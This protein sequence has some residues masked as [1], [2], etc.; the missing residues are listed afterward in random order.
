MWGQFIGDV[1]FL[2]RR[3][4]FLAE[5]FLDRL[6][7]KFMTNRICS[8]Q[9][10]LSFYDKWTFVGSLEMQ[11][12]VIF[13]F[14]KVFFHLYFEFI[15]SY[16]LAQFSRHTDNLCIEYLLSFS[17]IIS[18]FNCLPMYYVIFWILYPMPVIW[19][20]E[21]FTAFSFLRLVYKL[22][23]ITIVFYSSVFILF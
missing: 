21:K 13:H 23:F 16:L 17:F 8:C 3:C 7:V 11:I 18:F 5:C 2:Y 15:F 6:N 1:I 19:S 4:N 14:R 22:F 12:Y 20:S 10:L 9:S